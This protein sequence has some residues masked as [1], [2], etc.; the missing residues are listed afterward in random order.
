MFTFIVEEAES[1]R[2]QNGTSNKGRV[3]R[4][5]APYA[6]AKQGL[7]MLSGMTPRGTINIQRLAWI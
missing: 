2:L 6:F 5:N 3:G 7:A 1:L 4:S